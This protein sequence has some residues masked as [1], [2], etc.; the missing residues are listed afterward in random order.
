MLNLTYD[1]EVVQQL[2]FGRLYNNAIG[3]LTDVRDYRTAV[4]RFR[5]AAEDITI[6]T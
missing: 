2:G 6:V 3:C 1:Y 4:G 5:T